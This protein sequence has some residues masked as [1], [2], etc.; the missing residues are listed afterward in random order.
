ME[1]RGTNRTPCN[2]VSVS[3]VCEYDRT[4]KCNSIVI[5]TMPF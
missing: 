4:Q 2:K 1:C 3:Q 5:K